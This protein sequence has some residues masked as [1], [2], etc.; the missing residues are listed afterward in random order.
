MQEEIVTFSQEQLE[1][2]PSDIQQNIILVQDYVK[3]NELMVL[4]PLVSKLLSIKEYSQI[5]YNC[6]TP[7]LKKES[8]Q[9]YK[10]AIKET[11]SV[12]VAA[13]A[14]KTSLKK[15]FD[16]IGKAILSIEKFVKEEVL[17]VQNSLKNNF[18]EYI[19]EEEKKKKALQAKKDAEAKKAIEDLANQ[20]KEQ[21]EQILKMN[22]LNEIR[23]TREKISKEKVN[24]AVKNFDLKNLIELKNGFCTITFEH[25]VDGLDISILDEQS[26]EI[27]KEE[28]ADNLK[29][30]IEL[31]ESR[32]QI[33]EENKKLETSNIESNTE[34]KILQR[35]TPPVSPISSSPI[36]SSPSLNENMVF[37][38]HGKVSTI[39]P[40]ESMINHLEETLSFYKQLKE[41]AKEMKIDPAKFKKISGSVLLVN[42][43]LT[44]SKDL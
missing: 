6:E 17:A 4:N 35:P 21:N 41:E 19:D 13:G 10:D 44:Y 28:V 34:N 36:S 2:L 25:F 27:I 30:Y 26:L 40:Y 31:M 12:N 24:N 15:P 16:E 32:I 33:L 37:E 43:I 3:P 29:S 5:T 18:K 7:E 9:Q 39:D 42:K 23:I 8:I 38:L 11:K 14:A 20:N 22:L 1:I